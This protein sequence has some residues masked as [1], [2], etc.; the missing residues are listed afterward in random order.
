MA[1][2]F[3]LDFKDFLDFAYKIEELGGSDALKRATDNALT[4]TDKYVTEEV[5]KAIAQSRFNFDRTGRT[6]ES[7]DKEIKTE[8]DGTVAKAKAG[9]HITQGGLASQFLIY[10]TPHIAGDT[11]LRNAVK[12]EGKHKKVIRQLQKDEFSKVLNEVMRND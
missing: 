5:D 9:F 1:K 7:L 10:G 11:N 2:N 3:S 6:K 8:W 4:A 12:G